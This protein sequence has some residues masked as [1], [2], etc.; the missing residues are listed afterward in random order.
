MAGE[1][2]ACDKLWKRIS[3]TIELEDPHSLDRC[4]G[5]HHRE[6][7]AKFEGGFRVRVLTYDMCDFAKAC[8]ARYLEVSG[9]N[10]GALKKVATPFLSEDDPDPKG[11]GALGRLGDKAASVLMNILYAARMVRFDLLKAIQMLAS[12]IHKLTP[13]CDKAI[14]R[15]V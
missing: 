2:S 6:T 8:V 13:W 1:P 3:Q 9:G 11:E 5:C 12:R 15:L 4:L 7:T 14:H 10:A